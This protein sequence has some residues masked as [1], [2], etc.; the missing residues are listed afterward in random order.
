MKLNVGFM[1]GSKAGGAGAWAA[2]GVGVAPKTN[3]VDAAGATGALCCYKQN[4]HK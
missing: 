2:T 1:F 3:P 4:L